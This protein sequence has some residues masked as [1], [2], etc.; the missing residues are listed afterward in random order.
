MLKKIFI[1]AVFSRIILFAGTLF[2]AFYFGQNLLSPLSDLTYKLTYHWDAYSY[3]GIAREGYPL[4][5]ENIVR[6]VFPPLYSLSVKILALIIK[7]YYL[8][9]LILSNLFFLLG[10]L[11]FYKLLRLD[12]SVS[13]S[14]KAVLLLAFFPTAFFFSTAYAESLFFLLFCLSFFLIRTKKYSWAAIFCGLAYL[15]KPFGMILAFGLLAE[16]IFSRRFSTALWVAWLFS[17]FIG[18]YLS[19]NY[20][21]FR[22]IFAFQKFLVGYWHKSFTFPWISVRDTIERAFL[23][24]DLSVHNLIVAHAEALAAVTAWITVPLMFLKR[25]GIRKAYAVYYALGVLMM[26]STGFLLSLPRYLLSL[27]PFFIFLSR[28]LQN[29]FLFLF[30]LTLSGALMIYLA[31]IFVSGIEGGWA[32]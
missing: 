9:S 5:G 11:F 26:T 16:L 32:F 27:P 24:K 28:L 14:Q 17:L 8:S 25:L 12:Y 31:I 23:I 21:L 29:R 19:L 22:D 15:T 3:L 10:C 30:W 1:W 7:D 18:V 2:G 6:I 20:V 13:K 4:T